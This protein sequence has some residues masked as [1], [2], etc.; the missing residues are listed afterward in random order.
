MNIK[1]QSG[2]ERFLVIVREIATADH[3]IAVTGKREEIQRCNDAIKNE[4]ECLDEDG[5]R[6][7]CHRRAI[8][9]SDREQLWDRM[10]IDADGPLVADAILKAALWKRLNSFKIYLCDDDGVVVRK[11]MTEPQFRQQDWSALRV[12]LW[13]DHKVWISKPKDTVADPLEVLPVDRMP[14]HRKYPKQVKYLVENLRRL[15]EEPQ[16][17][18]LG[19]MEQSRRLKDAEITNFCYEQVKDLPGKPEPEINIESYRKLK[20]ALLKR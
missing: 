7:E 10:R 19:G 16:L 2:F 13:D 14:G 20:A 5:L 17:I 9:V 12:G 15:L 11:G 6:E 1:S 8:D 4:I 18:V 3:S